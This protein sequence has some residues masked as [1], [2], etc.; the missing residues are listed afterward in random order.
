MSDAV[1]PAR[2]RSRRGRTAGGGW[3]CSSRPRRRCSAMLV[4][5]LL[6]PAL[7]D[8]SHWP[9][10]RDRPS[11]RS[12]LPLVLAAAARGDQ[13]ADGARVRRGAARPA[14][15]A[16]SCCSPR[17]SCRAATSACSS[18]TTRATSTGSRRERDAYARSTSRCSARTTRTSPSACC[19]TPGCSCAL[20]PALT[21][22][23]VVGVQGDRPSTGTSSTCSPLLVVG[24][25][26][27]S[28]RAV[29]RDPRPEF[30]QWFGLLGGAARV[31]GAARRRLRRDG[32]A[33]ARVGALGIA[34]DAVA[35]RAARR[36]LRRRRSR[37]P[38]RS[39][40][41]PSRRATARRGAPR[42]AARRPRLLLLV[43]AALARQL[44]L[45]RGHPASS[46]GRRR[47]TL[48]LVPPVMTRR[49]ALAAARCV[50]PACRAPPRRVSA[51]RG[52][53]R[54]L[55]RRTA[56]R[57][58]GADAAWARRRGPPLDGVGAR[59]ADFYLRTGYMPLAR[60]DDQPRR[61]PRRCFA[62]RELRAL[63][64]YVASLGHGPARCRRR[65]RSAATSPRAC[66]CSPST[67]PAAT[68]SSAQGGYVTGA[69]RAAARPRRRRRRSPRRCGSART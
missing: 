68:R 10:R 32:G 42:R 25:H 57:C 5:T 52:A 35:D 14:R 22:Y 65:T 9:P 55:R 7:P 48:V 54:P 17:S 39:G 63:V 33:C 24:V 3:R 60:P 31:G 62:P 6:L 59:A 16:R 21:P 49:V 15:G 46:G 23:R 4:G 26:S 69:V 13:R 43:T 8:A 56:S 20:A 27:L 28:P 1:V 51:R 2:P 19:S 44:A 12:L 66:A 50:A 36:R 34:I 37:W 29:R 30:L 11:R 64:A 41:L 53:A 40:S 58:H 67:A 38:R 18:T 47:L 45:P 61:K